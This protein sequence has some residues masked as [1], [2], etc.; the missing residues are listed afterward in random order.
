MAKDPHSP[1]FHKDGSI[2][3]WMESRGWIY[4][5]H[6][7]K[8]ARR[9][10]GTFTDLEMRKWQRAMFQRGFVNAGG[11]WIPALSSYSHLSKKVIN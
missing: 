10:L 8:V 6:P 4:R 3:Y 5:V 7:S 2:T 9:A 11:Q 1:T